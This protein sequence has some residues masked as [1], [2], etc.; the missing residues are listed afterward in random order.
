MTGE[1]MTDTPASVYLVIAED[2]SYSD[3]FTFIAAGYAE[4]YEAE[5]RAVALAEERDAYRRAHH[6]RWMQREQWLRAHG[7]QW[8]HQL[9]NDL[10][11]QLNEELPYLPRSKVCT[12]D[13]YLVLELPLGE[14]GKFWPGAGNQG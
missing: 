2:G 9:P 3:Y 10:K 12:A 4:K 11:V 13:E 14:V 6:E 5:V 1:I 7:A 8:Y